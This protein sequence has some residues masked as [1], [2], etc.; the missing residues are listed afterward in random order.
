MSRLYLGLRADV[1]TG[2]L[3]AEQQHLRLGAQ[4]AGQQHLLLIAAGELG[5]PSDRSARHLDPQGVSRTC[6]RF[7]AWRA[8]RRRSPCLSGEA[9]VTRFPWHR[10]IDFVPSALRSSLP[11]ADAER[12]RVGRLARRHLLPVELDRSSVGRIRNNGA[13]SLVRPEPSRPADRRSGVRGLRRP[14]SIWKPLQPRAQRRRCGAGGGK[15]GRMGPHRLEVAPQHRRDQMQLVDLVIT[16]RPSR[17]TAT[18]S[19]TL[20]RSSSR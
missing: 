18:R 3:V 15:S 20:I 13:R 7:P 4:P 17:I 8:P 9:D 2:S 14:A 1:D 5:R 12:D 10:H 11:V 19:Q 16:V 6:R